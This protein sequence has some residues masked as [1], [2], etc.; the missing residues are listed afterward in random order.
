MWDSELTEEDADALLDKAAH[1]ILKRKMS[2]PA[3]LML[4][5]HRPF[6]R[7]AG[8]GT[9]VFAP[10]LVPFVGFDNVNNYSRLLAKPGAVEALL[11][12]LERGSMAHPI[13]EDVCSITTQAG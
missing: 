10:F 8:Q 5:M 9:I 13:T 1:E 12:R 2:V 11:Q 6:A 4:E 7:L 3:I